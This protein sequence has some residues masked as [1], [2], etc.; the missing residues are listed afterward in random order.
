[1]AIICGS[2]RAAEFFGIVNEDGSMNPN[3]GLYGLAQSLKLPISGRFRVITL[4]DESRCGYSI[5]DFCSSC[6]FYILH[7]P[8]RSRVIHI[9]VGACILMMVVRVLLD[10]SFYKRSDGRPSVINTDPQ[11]LLNMRPIIKSSRSDGSLGYAVNLIH[12]NGD[13]LRIRIAGRYGL[14]ESLFF[15]LFG[16]LEVFDTTSNMLRA[17]KDIMTSAV[18]LDGGIIRTSNQFEWGARWAASL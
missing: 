12:L 7:H 6:S 16:F 17:R 4:S 8:R 18:A 5:E 2:T 10:C 13:Q 9:H 3:E 15:V 11:K 14:R 1:M